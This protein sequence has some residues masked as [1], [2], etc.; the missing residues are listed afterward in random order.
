MPS[1]I[2]AEFRAAHEAI[3]ECIEALRPEQLAQPYW[4]GE[5]RTVAGKIAGDTYLHYDEHRAW[6]LEIMAEG[7]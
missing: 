6:I 4:P 1:D 2:R 7:D 5:E 3:V